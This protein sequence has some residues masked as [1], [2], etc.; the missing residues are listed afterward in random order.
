MTMPLLLENLIL[1][2]FDRHPLVGPDQRLKVQRESARILL[3]GMRNVHRSPRRLLRRVPFPRMVISAGFLG[4]NLGSRIDS[5]AAPARCL[6]RW[7]LRKRSGAL[8]NDCRRS[9]N[10]LVGEVGGRGGGI[11]CGSCGVDSSCCGSCF[12][13]CRVVALFVF[14]VLVDEFNKFGSGFFR[15]RQ[16]FDLIVV[17]VVAAVF[18]LVGRGGRSH[19]HPADAQVLSQSGLVLHAVPASVHVMSW[20]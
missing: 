5:C 18:H 4:H 3:N 11:S 2:L 16:N 7:L 15:G 8:G 6:W 14:F 19:A 1:P 20:W 13:S 9:V 10:G 12:C 17:I